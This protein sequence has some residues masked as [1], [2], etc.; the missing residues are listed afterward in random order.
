MGDTSSD[1][2]AGR[3]RILGNLGKGAMG[4]VFMAYDPVLDRKVA[5][6]Q[7]TA[8]IADNQE[9]RQRF[10][11]EA[12]A[13]ARLNHPNIITIH[14]LEESGGDIFMIM[15]MLDGK[16]LAAMIQAKPVPLSIEATLDVMAQVCDGLDYAHQRAIV[17]R[18][19]KP[20]NLFL[21]PSGAVKIL[22]FGIARLGSLHMTQAGAL[23][24]TP[25]Y[26]SPEQI[27]GDEIDR[28][29]D[30][31][32]VGAVLYQL[33]SG[34]KPFEG[35]PLSR[36]LSAIA[37]TPH[38]PLQQRA[39]SVPRAVSDLVDRLLSKPR[40]GRPATAGLV[41]DELRAILGRESAA[42]TRATL[43]ADEY[44]STLLL[45]PASDME[46]SPPFAP[47][48]VSAAA[49][50]AA[51]PLAGAAPTVL[52]PKSATSA[53]PGPGMARTA[54][55]PAHEVDRTVMMPLAAV[56]P[57]PLPVAA[58]PPVPTPGPAAA[59]GPVPQ[60]AAPAA[61]SPRVVPAPPA[62]PA[63]PAAASAFPAGAAKKSSP[64]T[65]IAAAVGAVVLLVAAG[66]GAWW[67]SSKPSPGPAS[68][69][70]GAPAA[71]AETAVPVG[72]PEAAPS[73]AAGEPVAPSTP[74]PADAA[75]VPLVPQAAG[76][77][78]PAAAE[79][80]Q[81]RQGSGSAAMTPA[82]TPRAQ[83]AVP[84]SA[85][86]TDA[87]AVP[88]PARRGT[89]AGV[90]TGVSA[91]PGARPGLSQDTV[92]AFKGQST[93]QGDES[94]ANLAAS[95]RVTYVLER[96]V[97]VLVNGDADAIREFRPSP[98]SEELELLRARQLKVRLDDVRVQ[99]N[100]SDAV[101]RC[102][103]KVEGTSASGAR[104]ELDAAVTFL[105]T[106]RPAGWV[107]TDVR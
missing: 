3:Y 48:A 58:V 9:L 1:T 65:L 2:I 97:Q 66:G 61:S 6:K 75:G 79:Q 27:R 85:P 30:L 28:R 67:Y 106:R 49:V 11:V 93:G 107:I 88:A 52:A 99:V 37:Q 77:P 94:A 96:Y 91:V 34:M 69:E 21:T 98:S 60:P 43:T 44:E 18:D 13:A 12:R 64:T 89:A 59:R 40:E 19:I 38:L 50:P 4:L 76:A 102:R 32:A 73:A 80:P 68:T 95:T 39:P 56:V 5:I 14:E 104:I 78:P 31:W 92:D 86:R 45:R 100:G 55:G 16:A 7:M 26:M 42:S 81:P 10:H 54:P 33:L 53:A 36:L 87:N 57:P 22:D 71:T 82:A 74:A 90:D 62:R 103:R 29:T 8:E 20:A 15:E 41:R 72:A 17:H 63:A 51:R 23:I 24:G 83:P 70:A 35:K 84:T 25:D 101:A 105:L 46:A 47:A